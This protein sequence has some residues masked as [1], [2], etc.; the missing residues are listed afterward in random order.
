M[1]SLLWPIAVTVWNGNVIGIFG[2]IPPLPSLQGLEIEKF[3]MRTP[4]PK[5]KTKNDPHL[6]VNI[7]AIERAHQYPHGTFHTRKI[8]YFVPLVMLW[9]IIW[10]NLKWT[11]IFNVQATKSKWNEPQ[12]TKVGLHLCYWLLSFSKT[13]C[14]IFLCKLPG[15]WCEWC[16]KILYLGKKSC[17]LVPQHRH[18]FIYCYTIDT[19]TN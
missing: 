17:T 9:T 8:Y 14:L 13:S 2:A 19:S 12:T 4:V 3:L 6:P 18:F 10:G 1:V 16:L 15:T 11:G 5:S 7:T